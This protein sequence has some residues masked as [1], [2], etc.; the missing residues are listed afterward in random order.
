[1]HGTKK[2]MPVYLQRTIT[3]L[4]RIWIN[5]GRRGFLVSLD[6]RELQRVL[7]PTLVDVA[8]DV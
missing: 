1:L 5:G 4:P 3:D 6:P 8:I 2:K 7:D